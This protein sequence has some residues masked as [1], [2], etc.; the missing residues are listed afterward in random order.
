MT[1]IQLPESIP[2][3]TPLGS[4]MAVIF[5]PGEHDN[6]WTVIL[7]SGAFVTFPQE[8]LKACRSYWP[9][10]RMETKSMRDILKG[11]ALRPGGITEFKP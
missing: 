7:E 6:A 11:E 8:Q 5:D 1:P 4:G 9:K 3:E 2:V 10:R